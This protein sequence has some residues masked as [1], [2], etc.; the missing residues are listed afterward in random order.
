[1]SFADD[2]KLPRADS[3]GNNKMSAALLNGLKA[4]IK[5]K[6][7]FRAGSID[8]TGEERKVR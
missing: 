7:I 3:I 4:S 8:Q 2:P 1:M 5:E 6:T